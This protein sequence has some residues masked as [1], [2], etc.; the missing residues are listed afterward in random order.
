MGLLALMLL[1]ESRR[2]ARVTSD[3]DLILLEAQDRK[4]WNQ[5]FIKE[6]QRLVRQSLASGEA[7]SYSI[8]AAILCGPCGSCDGCRHGLVQIVSLYDLLLRIN[9]SPVIELNRA[10]AVAMADGPAAGCN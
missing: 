8:Q 5:D 10:V 4:S 9:P 3:G 1:H 6:G 7:G 2:T